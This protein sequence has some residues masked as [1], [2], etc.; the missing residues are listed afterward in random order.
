[1]TFWH[2]GIEEES[3]NNI[4]PCLYCCKFWENHGEK[5]AK[6]EKENKLWWAFG[7]TGVFSNLIKANQTNITAFGKDTLKMLSKILPPKSKNA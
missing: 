3:T 2:K 5:N 6:R 4:L 7:E 1:M